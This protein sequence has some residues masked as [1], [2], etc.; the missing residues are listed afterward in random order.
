MSVETN[1]CVL[2]SPDRKTYAPHLDVGEVP[3]YVHTKSTRNITIERGWRPLFYTWGVN[4]LHFY[5]SGRYGPSSVYREGDIVHEYVVYDV[6]LFRGP[7]DKLI[8][9]SGK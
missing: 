2:N 5:D 6:F 4:I 3:A 9:P 8:H 7:N 1:S